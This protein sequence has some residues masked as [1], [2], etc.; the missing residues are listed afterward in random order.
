MPKYASISTQQAARRGGLSPRQVR[1]G[2]GPIGL[3]ANNS[4]L[5]MEL[6]GVR[7]MRASLRALG[8]DRLIRHTIKRALKKAAEPAEKTA[9]RLAP[10]GKETG[11]PHMADKVR[12]STTLSKRQR[13]QQGFGAH[14]GNPLNVAVVYIGAGPR[15]PAVLA[16][17][18]TGPRKHK[19]GKST[20]MMPA[21]PFMRTAWEQHKHQILRDFTKELWNQIERSAKR[22]ARRQA[23][24]IRESRK[25]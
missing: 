15:G 16:E 5:Q 1:A 23:K 11:K 10:R 19:S 7:D 9:Q 14:R 25:R 3:S 18:G 21:T 24:L 20:G 17:F 13:R 6:K 2:G 8:K 22:L 12:V 4:L